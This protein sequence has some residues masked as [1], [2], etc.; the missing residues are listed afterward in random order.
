MASITRA[1]INIRA[2][3]LAE[4]KDFGILR[5]IVSDIA[6]AREVLGEA[7]V[8][9]ETPVIA[10][11]MNDEAGAL[12]SILKVLSEA[13]VNIEY[14]YAFTGTVQGNAY[15]VFRVDETG[16]AERILADKGI[17]TLSDEDMKE[18]LS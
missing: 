5:I 7:T 4:T 12:N 16:E 14:I 8:I 6:K 18:L 2:L 17:A 1:G 10:V 15:V 13:N 9:R 11:K 3:S